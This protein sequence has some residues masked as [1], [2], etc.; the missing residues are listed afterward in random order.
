MK[1]ILTMAAL[2]AAGPALA[3]PI[4]S[5]KGEYGPYKYS[6]ELREDYSGKLRIVDTRVDNGDGTSGINQPRDVTV[7]TTP[8]NQP[9]GR[10]GLQFGYGDSVNYAARKSYTWDRGGISPA[11]SSNSRVK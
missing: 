8:L 10:I 9:T 1:Y 3:D 6:W 7:T 11:R 5:G 4:D 2:L